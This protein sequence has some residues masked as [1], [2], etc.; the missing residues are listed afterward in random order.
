MKAEIDNFISRVDRLEQRFE[1]DEIGKYIDEWLMPKDLLIAIR[2]HLKAPGL[3]DWC[4]IEK[5]KSSV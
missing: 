3:F 1:G 2:N 4:E 5:G